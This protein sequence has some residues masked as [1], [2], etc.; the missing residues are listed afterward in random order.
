VYAPLPTV[1]MPALPCSL[2]VG[3]L[4]RSKRLGQPVPT[5]TPCRGKDVECFLDSLRM[6]AHI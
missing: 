2:P 6:E 5:K 3:S 4:S 1:A